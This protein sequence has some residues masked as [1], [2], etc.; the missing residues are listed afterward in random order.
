MTQGR[1]FPPHRPAVDRIAK[2]LL[3]E[4]PNVIAPGIEQRALALL[5]EGGEL[6][7]VGLVGSDGKRR[8]TLF[9]FQVVEKPIDNSMRWQR[10]HPA[11]YARYRTLREV[12]I[13][14][15]HGGH[16][17]RRIAILSVLCVLRGY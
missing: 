8:Q 10:R 16:R 15:N 17:T 11:K 14:V 9:D 6:P 13:E 4:L 5:Q 12:S 1:K 7:Y 3:D 2:Q